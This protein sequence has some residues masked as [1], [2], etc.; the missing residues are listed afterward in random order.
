MAHVR[1]YFWKEHVSFMSV[2]LVQEQQMD[3][4][5][6]EDIIQ[7]CHSFF[8]DDTR[9]RRTPVEL[10]VEGTASLSHKLDEH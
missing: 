8:G 10:K 7:Y 4:A 9:D 3:D 1:G 6:N 2:Y 5:Y